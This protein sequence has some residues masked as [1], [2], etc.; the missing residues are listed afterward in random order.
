MQ[1]SGSTESGNS[2]THWRQQ[3]NSLYTTVT[4][5]LSY[6][7][8]RDR[9]N[10]ATQCYQKA[11]EFGKTDDDLASA[12][13]NLA[14]SAWKLV[15]LLSDNKE[16]SFLD[17]FMVMYHCKEAFKYFSYSHNRGQNVKSPTWLTGLY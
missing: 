7:L 6:V 4:E 2:S 17:A 11:F 9:L 14:M 15:K 1:A 5:G 12:A 3:G 8:S 13:K 10:Q 16:R